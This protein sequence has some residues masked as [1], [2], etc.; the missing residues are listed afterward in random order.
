L[1]LTIM[2][3]SSPVTTTIIGTGWNAD[4]AIRAFRKLESKNRGN[5]SSKR[6]S[7]RFSTIFGST[8]ENASCHSNPVH[9]HN[10]NNCIRLL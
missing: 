5:L 2:E 7:S 4:T 3:S 8:K 6:V 9:I 10:Q 1:P